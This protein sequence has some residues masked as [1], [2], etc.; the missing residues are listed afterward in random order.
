[1]TLSEYVINQA[2]QWHEAG[3]PVVVA[4]IAGVRGSSSQP[5]GSRMAITDGGEFAGYVSGGCVETD[6]YEQ[7]QQVFADG[8]P[9]RLH[10]SQTKD[11]LFE[12]GL[13]CEGQIEVVLE[14]LTESVLADLLV[15]APAVRVTSYRDA[16]GSA[17]RDSGDSGEVVEVHHLVLDETNPSTST[18][19]P[20]VMVAIDLARKSR[21]PRTTTDPAGWNHLIEPVSR[22]PTL[23]IVSA[24]SVAYPLSRLGRALGYRVVISDPR[25]DYLAP[26]RFPDAELLLPIWPRELPQ[27]ITFGPECVVVSLNHEPRFE[28][29]LFRTL[30]S[31][32]A[33]SYVGAIGKRER[34]GERVARQADEGYDLAQLPVIHT[35][36]GLDLGGKSPEEIALSILAEIQAVHHGRS[37]GMPM[38]A[39]RTDSKTARST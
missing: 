21:F 12:I 10:Y 27:H 37:G 8:A 36:V 16:P 13:N 7:S 14:L 30:Q 2:R 35:P 19:P 33:V 29:D 25:A 31:E 3:R 20:E 38:P 15:P 23:L 17:R 32:P 26:D 11:F 5:L 28:D 4:T 22:K 9:R 34:H 1:V 39:V 24:S 6:V 18:L